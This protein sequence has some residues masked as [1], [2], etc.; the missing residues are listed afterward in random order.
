MFVLSS[1]PKPLVDRIQSEVT[2][3]VHSA[4]YREALTTQGLDFPKD[5]SLDQL[6]QTLND[7]TAHNLSII[8]KLQLK[9]SPE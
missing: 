6:R 2:K 1:T 9:I 7:T 5:A 3:A 4:K 8:K